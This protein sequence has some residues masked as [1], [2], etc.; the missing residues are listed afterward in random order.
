MLCAGRL[1]DL[2]HPRIM[3][4]LNVTPDSFSDGGRL[5]DARGR[6][7]LEAIVAE[8]GA[9]LEA[10]AALLDVGGESTRPGARPVSVAE[11]LDR[12]IPV[13]AALQDLATIVS[14]D[15]RH[16][17][18]AR[19][20]LDAGAHMI[21]DVSAGADPAMLEL[22]GGSDAAFALMHMQGQPRTMQEA[23]RYDNV[24]DEV[25][26]FLDHRVAA[27]EA[28]AIGRDRLLLDPGFGFGKTMAHNL[29][30]LAALEAVRVADLPMLVG[31]S[32]K[33]MLGTIT[34]RAVEERV[35]ASIAAALLAVERGADIVRVHDVAGTADALK[36]REALV[37]V[38]QV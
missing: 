10:G 16:A 5:L 11:E 13:V 15:T 2:T 31:L 9:M 22:L 17:E 32:R 25:R 1:L 26:A 28:A 36:V 18:V 23:P 14:V 6:P 24:V 37:A 35:A 33:S 30:L 19:A 4:V 8:A 3:G 20:A 29:R 7:A 27:C 34:G 21:N 38:Q 12:V